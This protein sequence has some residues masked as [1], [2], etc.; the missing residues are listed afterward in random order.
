[1]EN[2]GQALGLKNQLP[3][4][5]TLSKVDVESELKKLKTNK[6]FM[7]FEKNIEHLSHVMETKIDD[8]EKQFAPSISSSGH[9]TGHEFPSNVW[10]LTFDDGPTKTTAEILKVLKEKQVRATFFQIASR[11]DEDKVASRDVLKSGMEVGSHSWNHVQLTKVG[12][13]SLNREIAQASNRIENVAGKP[14]QFYRL[15]YGSGVSTNHIREK[16]SEAGYIHAGWNVD[17]LDWLPQ[18][19]DKIVART[20]KLMGKTSKDSGIIL[21][22]DVHP[23]TVAALPKLIDQMKSQD[24]RFCTLSEIVSDMNEGS[25]SV[26]AKK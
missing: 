26:C 6:E 13:S 3:E 4:I 11:V 14:V 24:Q 22:H 1:M 19:S 9:V 7:L 12:N 8:G 16:I 21:L 23:R 15:P 20:I 10:T 25:T 18:P 17:A 5:K 2:L